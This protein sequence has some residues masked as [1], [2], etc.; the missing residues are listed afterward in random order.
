MPTV[1]NSHATKRYT[2][3]RIW[4]CLVKYSWV[5]KILQFLNQLS[6]HERLNDRSIKLL[7]EGISNACKELFRNLGCKKLI[8]RLS[9]RWGK[10]IILKKFK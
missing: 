4:S 7:K 9:N 2:G 3:H 8:E 6:D 5:N 10:G 1:E